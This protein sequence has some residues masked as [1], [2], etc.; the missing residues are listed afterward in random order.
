MA[1][2]WTGKLFRLRTWTAF[3][4]S[5]ATS[6]RCP[7]PVSIACARSR[8]RRSSATTRTV[9]SAQFPA[10]VFVPITT[11]QH[12]RRAT[13]LQ[14]SIP[15]ASRNSK[16]S[17]FCL[18]KIAHVLGS[19]SINIAQISESLA[20]C[21]RSTRYAVCFR[22]WRCQL[23]A[24]AVL[25]DSVDVEHGSG[26]PS[27]PSQAMERTASRRTP[28]AF[29]FEDVSLATRTHAS[30]VSRRQLSFAKTAVAYSCRGRQTCS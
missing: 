6:T 8:T 30:S 5:L 7:L 13:R 28:A 25:D 11:S 14:V 9:C 23:R 1:T 17:T 18:V 24:S 2:E 21:I 4:A 26:S 3:S 12:H 10:S 15:T 22:S 27:L 20:R 29:K 16:L 19:I